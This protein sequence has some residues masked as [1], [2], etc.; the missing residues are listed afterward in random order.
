MSIYHDF[1]K[2]AEAFKQFHIQL[3][4]LHACDA[5][6]F[7]QIKSHFNFIDEK[8]AHNRQEA[9]HQYRERRQ[10]RISH[11]FGRDSNVKLSHSD[12]QRS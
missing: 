5:T 7:L 2:I 6:K 8:S 10:E 1:I 9:L 11:K 3:L 4:P 12:R